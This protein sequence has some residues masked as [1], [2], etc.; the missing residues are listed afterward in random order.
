MRRSRASALAVVS[1]LALTGCGPSTQEITAMISA[2]RS[3]FEDALALREAVLDA[4]AECPGE[5]QVTDPSP[6]TDSTV[7]PCDPDLLLFVAD[8]ED[9]AAEMIGNLETIDDIHYLNSGNWVAASQDRQRLETIQEDLG[10]EI[11]STG[12]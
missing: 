7:L 8:G 6:D 4:G 5:Q 9:M 2:D 10:G 1:A 12:S 3:T 11:T